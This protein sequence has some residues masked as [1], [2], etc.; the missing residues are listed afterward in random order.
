MVID[1][2]WGQNFTPDLLDSI[3]KQSCLA[4]EELRRIASVRNSAYIVHPLLVILDTFMRACQQFFT[5]CSVHILGFKSGLPRHCQCIA[6]CS[7]QIRCPKLGS[8][9]TLPPCQV[10]FETSQLPGVLINGAAKLWTLLGEY[11][12]KDA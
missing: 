6:A 7:I 12:H 11:W 8:S 10:P 2:T 3:L 5:Q 1:I 4:K 9:A